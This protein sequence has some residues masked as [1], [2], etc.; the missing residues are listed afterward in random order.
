MKLAVFHEQHENQCN[1]NPYSETIIYRNG[2]KPLYVNDKTQ[3]NKETNETIHVI[4]PMKHIK[5]SPGLSMAMNKLFP[6]KWR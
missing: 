2:T 3:A 6:K 5:P 4:E 1:K